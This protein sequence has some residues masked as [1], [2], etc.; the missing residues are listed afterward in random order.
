VYIDTVA[1]VVIPAALG[2]GGGVWL[3]KLRERGDQRQWLRDRRLTAA[4]DWLQAAKGAEIAL[5]QRERSANFADPDTASRLLSEFQAAWADA[6]RETSRVELLFG[7]ESSV[8]D[9][10]RKSVDPQGYG[11]RTGA[12]AGIWNA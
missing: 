3:Q 9:A 1:L 2:L 11:R 8:A 7:S 12:R 5:G 4:D 6:A 10:A